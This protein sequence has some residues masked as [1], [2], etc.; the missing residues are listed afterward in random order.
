MQALEGAYPERLLSVLIAIGTGTLELH[1]LH[2][3]PGSSRGS[4]KPRQLR[5]VYELLA[6]SSPDHR[7]LCGDFN[8]PQLEHADGTV[9]TWA[10]HH[11]GSFEDW[12]A[13]ERNV[14][15]GLAQHDLSDL[16]RKLHGYGRT[17]AS[18]IPN[19]GKT[20][21]G[22]RFDHVFASASLRGQNCHYLHEWRERKLSDHS[23]I[24][25]VFDPAG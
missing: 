6:R 24:E 1:N 5:A 15:L 18:W 14:L 7:V 21:I 12:D 25:A 8:T 11:A 4:D 19:H 20:R 13:A 23:A 2:V 16:F 22:R 17:D 3:V 10:D 9:V